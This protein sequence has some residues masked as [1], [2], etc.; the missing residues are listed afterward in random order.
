MEKS[1]CW[2]YVVGVL[3]WGHLV[4]SAFRSSR[5]TL[6]IWYVSAYGVVQ[7]FHTM[8]SLR[9]LSNEYFGNSSWIRIPNLH[10]STKYK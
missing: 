7:S 6:I 9:P 10:Q 2:G 3:G 5:Y 8:K 1:F 4:I